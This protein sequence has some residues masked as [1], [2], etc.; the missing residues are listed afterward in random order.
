MSIAE[1]SSIILYIKDVEKFL[2]HSK[3]FYKL[4][5]KLLSKL[6]GSVLVVGSC[7]LGQDEDRKLDKKVNV[8]FPCNIEIKAA[9]EEISLGTWK[10]QAEEET[11]SVRFLEKKNHIAEVLATN[12]LHCDDLDSIRCPDSM[13][14]SKCT[15]DIVLSA[16]SHHLRNNK[17]PKYRNGKLVISSKRYKAIAFCYYVSLAS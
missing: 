13:I 15:E 7:V 11:K 12:D 1:T 5:K 6:S 8:L 2:L 10:A 3:R 4:F 14:L 16:V 9:E 17:D